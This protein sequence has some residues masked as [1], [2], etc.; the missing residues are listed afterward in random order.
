MAH[1]TPNVLPCCIS[2]AWLSSYPLLVE[3]VCSP[4][5]LHTCPHLL[6]GELTKLGRRMAEF[7]LDPMLS[8][9]L[10][11]SET[12]G[13]SDQVGPASCSSLLRCRHHLL[14]IANV[15]A[16]ARRPARNTETNT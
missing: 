13:V 15:T 3:L 10:L 2:C 4:I 6:Q 9:M 7:P 1:S 12:Y 8:K 16:H 11:A 14:V 5:Y